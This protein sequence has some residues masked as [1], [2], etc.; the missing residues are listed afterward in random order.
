MKK[1]FLIGM[2][3]LTA[4]SALAV[5]AQDFVGS[6]R[7]VNSQVEGDTFCYQGVI[8]AQE[9]ERLS[10]YRSDITEGALISAEVNGPKREVSFSHG[11][12]LSKTKGKES[13]TLDDKG[14]LTFEFSGVESLLG[15]PA[16]RTAD[17][18]AMKLSADGKSLY[19]VRKTFDGPVAG[20]GKN[21][22]ALCEYQRVK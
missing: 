17:G 19:A 6:Y 20:L 11:E 13:V 22:K 9:D 14:T 1:T 8:V 4:N 7:L 5:T 2:M 21:A 10:L 3:L 12:A 15:I 16:M 18:V